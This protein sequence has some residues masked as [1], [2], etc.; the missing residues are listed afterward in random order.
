MIGLWATIFGK[1]TVSFLRIRYITCTRFLGK[2]VEEIFSNSLIRYVIRKEVITVKV[3]YI[4]V[5]ISKYVLNLFWYLRLLF[6]F[7]F[8]RE[9]IK[10]STQCFTRFSNT[11]FK[12]ISLYTSYCQLFSRCWKLDAPGIY[13]SDLQRPSRLRDSTELHHGNFYS[14]CFSQK[15]QSP[16]RE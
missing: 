3:A 13:F 7:L 12:N 15:T 9:D 2:S 11:F 8:G 10:H 16:T 5:L 1:M 4:L 14:F 6:N